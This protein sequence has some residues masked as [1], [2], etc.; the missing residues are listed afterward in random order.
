MGAK[1]GHEFRGRPSL[2]RGGAPDDTHVRGADDRVF[3]IN[4]A[5]EDGG[6]HA[7]EAFVFETLREFAVGVVS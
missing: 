6:A 1:H 2:R 3:P 7:D 4:R 5:V